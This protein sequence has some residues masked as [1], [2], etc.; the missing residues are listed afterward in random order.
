MTIIDE[1][2]L[3][4]K[5]HVHFIGIGGSGMFPLV[6]IL[7]AEG[8]YITGSDNNETDTVNYER[9]V[10]GIPVTIGQ[11]AQNIEGADLI[12]Y[13]SAIL[14]DNEE[15]VAALS[16]GVPCLERSQLLGLI[17]G[18]Y[19]NCICVSGT[20]GKTT[21][22]AM[23]TQIVLGA[24][25]DP[26]AVIGGKLPVIH[27][28]GRVGKSDVMVCEACE[29]CDHFL[30]LNPDISII[31]N[32]DADHLD[33]FGTLDN[34]IA[35]FRKFAQKTTKLLI[36]NGDNS[37]SMKAV[38]GLDKQLITF[39]WEPIND[40]Y[41]A[42]IRYNKGI[43]TE[44]DLMYH[45]ELVQHIELKVPGK[46]NILNATAACAA[47]LYVGAKPCDLHEHLWEFGGAGRR[48]QVMGKVRGITI[49]DDYAHHPAELEVT[50]RTAKEMDFNK[51]WAVF[52]P[53]TYSRTA[54]LLDDFVRVL[55]IA[56]RVVMS[57]IMGS[58]EVNTYNIYTKDLA[59][60]IDGSVWY[61]TFEEM[62]DYVMSHAEDGDLVITLG[63]GD[64]N[65][66]AKMMVED[67]ALK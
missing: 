24:G 17:T 32:I 62:A 21:T 61:N 50:L 20:H 34:I 47:A 16:S 43:H 23:L 36:V 41:P 54:L 46:H 22:S 56:D 49:V 3:E 66:C 42:N 13:T 37:N 30:M 44:F 8:Y 38:E 33:Y 18:K 39:G 35:S 1:N 29:F 55:S 15:L 52:Q 45:G 7:H 4:G 57:E 9:E 53:F 19:S 48:F 28:S 5:K 31:L 2:I 59:D 65:K 25:L 6:Q 11:Y 27:G 67:Y 51:V 40:Y 60:K 10:L 12:V 63:C 26:T 58:R 64:I 14:K